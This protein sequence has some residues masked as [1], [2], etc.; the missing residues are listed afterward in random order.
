VRRNFRARDAHN[1][2]AFALRRNIYMKLT[3]VVRGVAIRFAR[4][5]FE[6][7]TIRAD[8]SEDVRWP[9]GHRDDRVTLYGLHASARW[10]GSISMRR[11][12]RSLSRRAH[13]ARHHKRP[14][15]KP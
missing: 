4:D 7:N 15:D 5:A 13:C 6:R 10:P 12:D 11:C 8:A 14:S 3:V 1:R 2:Q 9:L